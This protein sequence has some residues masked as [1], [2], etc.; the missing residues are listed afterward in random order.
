M[1]V[2]I[3]EKNNSDTYNKKDTKELDRTYGGDS[4]QIQ[5]KKKRGRPIIQ[6]MLD[7]QMAD[8]CAS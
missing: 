3:G 7:C 1:R 6:M 8:G 4:L 2:M 5:V